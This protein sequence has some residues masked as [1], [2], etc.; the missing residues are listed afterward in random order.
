MDQTVKAVVL[1]NSV[2]FDIIALFAFPMV[3]LLM[4]SPMMC[5]EYLQN[6]CVLQK[7]NF[8]QSSF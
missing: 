6:F 3:A 1:D 4:S 5:K 2:A 7:L 8:L